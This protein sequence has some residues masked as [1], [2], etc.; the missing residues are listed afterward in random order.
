MT[1]RQ[2]MLVAGEVARHEA[3][4]RTAAQPALKRSHMEVAEALRAALAGASGRSKEHCPRKSKSHPGLSR[5]LSP[6]GSSPSSG[7]R[8]HLRLLPSIR[9]NQLSCRDGSPSPEQ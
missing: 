8:I 7:P 3:L 6:V 2:A 1:A 5:K 9:R 4:A